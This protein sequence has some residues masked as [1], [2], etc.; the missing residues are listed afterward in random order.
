MDRHADVTAKMLDHAILVVGYG[1]D[2]A[3]GKDYWKV[4]NSWGAK[5]GE[6]GYVRMARNVGSVGICGLAIDA[7]FPLLG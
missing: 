7:S 3:S 6:Q 4:K 2:A 1:T 5:W